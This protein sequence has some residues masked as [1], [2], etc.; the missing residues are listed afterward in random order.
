MQ[1]SLTEKQSYLLSDLYG[2]TIRMEHL[3]RNLLL[4]AKIDNAQYNTMEE[5]DVAAYLSEWVPLYE[6]LRKETNIILND[7]RTQRN[8]KIN[9]NLTLL[10][11]LLKNLIVNAIRHSLPDSDIDIIL[12]DNLLTVCNVSADGHSLDSQTLFR[13]FH[14]G[15]AM[16]K[17]NGLGLS[18]VK[19]VCDFHHWNI[20]Y[21]F[22]AGSHQFMVNFNPINNNN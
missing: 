9:A 4:L 22:Y 18:I 6:T 10:E 14:T 20:E 15:D 13:R 17:G 11:C 5:V 12:E 1:E 19:A 7:R 21:R 3:N 2:L 16:Q 8:K